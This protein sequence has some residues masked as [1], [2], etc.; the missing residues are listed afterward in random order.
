[1]RRIFGKV[2][3]FG[4]LVLSS[5]G[6]VH[7]QILYRLTPEELWARLRVRWTFVRPIDGAAS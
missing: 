3:F 1:M 2:I 5:M 6:V 4:L 7:A